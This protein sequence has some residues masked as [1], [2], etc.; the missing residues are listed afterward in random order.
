MGCSRRYVRLVLVGLLRTHVGS[1]PTAF[2]AET[3]ESSGDVSSEATADPCTCTSAS[4]LHVLRQNEEL[5]TENAKLLAMLAKFRACQD[6]ER[7]EKA[8]VTRLTAS[9][10]PPSDPPPHPHFDI[11]VTAQLVSRTL[12]LAMT[13]PGSLSDRL[14]LQTQVAGVPP[15][16][17]RTVFTRSATLKTYNGTA[18]Q[19]LSKCDLSGDAFGQSFNWSTPLGSTYP[20]MSRSQL[21]PD[22]SRPPGSLS[23]SDDFAVRLQCA[24]ST[25]ICPRDGDT[26]ETVIDFTLSNF[27]KQHSSV[28][29]VTEVDA[30]PSCQLSTVSISPE[31]QP[32]YNDGHGLVVS[33]HIFDVDGFPI[34]YTAPE[35][36]IEWLPPQHSSASANGPFPFALPSDGP[37]HEIFY[38]QNPSQRHE[39]DSQVPI[40]LLQLPGEH[41]VTVR[42][43]TGWSNAT[44]NATACTVFQRTITVQCSNAYAPENGRCVKQ[45]SIFTPPIMVA[46]ICGVVLVSITLAILRFRY[47][48]SKLTVGRTRLRHRKAAYAQLLRRIGG[49]SRGKI[50]EMNR[51]DSIGDLPIHY[52]SA[53]CAPAHVLGAI[54]TAHPLSASAVDSMGNLP[55]H[56][57]LQ[58]L[59]REKPA[60]EAACGSVGTLVA[61][62]PDA[63][64]SH[65]EAAKLPIQI[66]LESSY[67]SVPYETIE[68]ASSASD[69]KREVHWQLLETA[70]PSCGGSGSD[71]RIRLGMVL[72]RPFDCDGLADNWLCLLEH[73][74]RRPSAEVATTAASSLSLLG[75]E[76]YDFGAR[77]LEA[78]VL[79]TKAAE[80]KLPIERLAYAT[81][82]RGR[83]AYAVATKENR[84]YLWKHLL[85]L[86]R[87]STFSHGIVTAV[88]PWPSGTFCAYR[89]PLSLAGIGSP[90][91]SRCIR[92]PQRA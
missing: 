89:F 7:T 70:A 1:L 16:Q 48:R 43:L 25:S 90:H 2:V 80:R 20:E 4:H 51:A 49:S 8:A 74:S 27:G 30:L 67:V 58:S 76:A 85:L 57:M 54:L 9:L 71:V 46:M 39:Y 55:L 77:V 17:M 18:L 62:Y 32:V 28:T 66:L 12:R 61:A 6:D 5:R 42:L 91:S 33:V 38:R 24:G 40:E 83:E 11:D 82:S 87:Y 22:A 45:F 75:D 60:S 65:D 72:G 52:A 53:C 84:R 73:S 44:Q 47:L 13:K 79:D 50:V 68:S 59:E 64:L 36:M 78:I 3:A 37:V 26:I 29:I 69:P 31:T 86:G 92:V 41:S 14:T 63:V 15:D 34:D 88:G 23:S 19:L 81:D 21:S 10:D 35:L 56:L